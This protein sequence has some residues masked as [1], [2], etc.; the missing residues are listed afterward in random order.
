MPID[1]S[2]SRV[3][4][5]VDVANIYRNGGQRMRYDVLREFACRDG[6]EPVRLNAYVSYDSDRAVEDTEYEIKVTGFHSAL[7]DMGF[8]VIVKKVRWYQDENGGRVAK[9]NADLDL[10]VDAL[11]QSE[12]LDRVLIASGDGDF[13]Q[14]VRALQNKGCRVE[15]V[16]LEN[17][18]RDLREEADLFVSGYLVPNLI[19]YNSE[20]QQPWGQPGSRVRGWCYWHHRQEPFG[21]MRYLREIAPGLWLTDTRHP[22][23]PY[24]TAFFHDT[25]LPLEAD[26]YELPNRNLVFE[27][28]LIQAEQ[29]EGQGLQAVDIDLISPA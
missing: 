15:I 24:G 18:S 17:V 23:S 9:A 7:R 19:P 22:D 6:G 1:R 8:K 4:V 13:V 14:V 11:L 26:P 16:A 5:Y 3:G 25:Q 21:F 10:A 20:V 28:K 29:R 2:P 27:F 12:N